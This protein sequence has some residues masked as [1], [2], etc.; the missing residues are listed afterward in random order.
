VTACDSVE[1]LPGRSNGPTPALL[2]VF[3]VWRPERLL[4][5]DVDARLMR[6][7]ANVNT[8][9]GAA[10]MLIIERWNN[11]V[12]GGLPPVD[13]LR[14]LG[15]DLAELGKDMIARADEVGRA[16]AAPDTGHG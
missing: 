16:V 3:L 10:L 13:D 6:R 1:I 15:T 5:K 4:V 8:A 14:S 7:L 11:D 9:L 2:L 12:D